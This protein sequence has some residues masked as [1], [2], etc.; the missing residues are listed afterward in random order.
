MSNS[1]FKFIDLFAGIGGFRLALEELGGTCVA[2]SEIANDAISVYRKNWNDGDNHNLGDI[3]NI[4]EL[5]EHDLIVGGVPCQSWS[6]AGKN[7]GAEDDRGKLWYEVI[8]LVSKHKPKAFIFENV[9]GLSDPRHRDSL[10]FL[11]DSFSKANYKVEFKVLNSY[12]FGVPQNRDRIFIVGIRRDTLVND[13][14]WPQSV[15]NH[16]CLYDFLNIEKPKGL[17]LKKSNIVQRDLFGNRVNVGFNKLT[18]LGEKNKFFVF[19]DIRNGPT[20]IHSWELKRTNKRQRMICETI[21]KNR[22]KPIYGE[23]DGNPMSFKDI[24]GL[25]PDLSKD[26]LEDLIEKSILRTYEDG[27]YE[28]KNRRISGGIDG[29]YRIY[30][31]TSSFFSTLTASGTK[32]LIATVNIDESVECEEEYKKQ[33]VE[34]IFKL[35]NFRE[36]EAEEFAV[37]QGFPKN[38]LL[39]DSYQKNV[40]LFGNSV[41]VPV[42]Q[43]IGESLLNV[44][45]SNKEVVY[46]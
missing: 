21:M 18:P 40:K 8:R 31:P 41:S 36:L 32:D 22:R 20:S 35:K 16:K 43:A 2:S 45:S 13:F 30:L 4:D 11:L 5:P 14:V 33:F 29:I 1:K 23:C 7:K 17:K 9:K 3:C 12:D 28:F 38:F 25:I 39:H 26:E 24:Q 34:N 10:N 6:I 15:A 19:T 37:I 46:A 27:R 44:I 42:I